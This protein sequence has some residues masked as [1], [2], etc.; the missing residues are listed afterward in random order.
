MSW[1]FRA[2]E[3]GSGALAD[4]GSH[5]IDLAAFL[6]GTPIVATVGTTRTLIRTRPTAA[7]EAADVDVDDTVAFL[8]T[9]HGGALASFEASRNVA[10]RKNAL[11]LEIYGDVGTATFDLERPN[12]LNLF[13]PRDGSLTEGFRTV[14]VTEPDHPYLAAWW[15]P[16]HVL[17]WEHSFVHELHDF[18][19]AVSEGR[20]PEPGFGQGLY[21]Q[22]V[23]DTVLRSNLGWTPVPTGEAA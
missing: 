11:H 2:T 7:G 22:R 20:Q 18:V 9:L 4:L 5:L 19:V 14:L 21:V 1:R 10:G 8:A 15:P 16:G 6:T 13:Q 17:G 23:I 12:E 3:A